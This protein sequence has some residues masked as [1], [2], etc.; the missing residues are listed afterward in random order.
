MRALT[1]IICFC[2]LP[3]PRAA[4]ILIPKQPDY[5]VVSDVFSAKVPAGKC[6]VTGMVKPGVGYIMP[7][8]G[9]II[10][11]L[12]RSKETQLDSSGH[13][14]ILLSA[15]DTALFFYKPPYQEI[16]IWKYPFQSQHV[17]T[18]DFYPDYSSSHQQENVLKPVIYLYSDTEIDVTLK[19]S[20]K[21]EQTYS[22]PSYDDGWKVRV[23]SKGPTDKETGIV[24][25]YLFWEGQQKDLGF[26]TE[27]GHIEGFV[28]ATDTVT[29]FLENT[30][31]ALGLNETEKTDFITFWGPRMVLKPFALVQFFVD[32]SYAEKVA[33][34]AINPKP[35]A[36][37]R[38]YMV[39]APLENPEM[40]VSVIAQK[41]SS[42]ER[43]GFTVVEWGGSQ[44]SWTHQKI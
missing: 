29:D 42:F 8:S 18:I 2:F 40:R 23:S 5:Q 3:G 10:A 14:S 38:I 32:D 44:L 27:N 28:I 12:D 41:F 35:D 39:F 31:V 34:L 17:V 9:G 19:L 25:P 4:G 1:I 11:T 20:C 37:R 6:L 33:G 7:L 43:R 26:G 36:M 21:G 15:A 13:Y 22:Y 30:L 16:V 24:Y